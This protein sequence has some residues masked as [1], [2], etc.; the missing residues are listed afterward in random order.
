MMQSDVLQQT[1]ALSHI[2]TAP[3]TELPAADCSTPRTEMQAGSKKS[4]DD[5]IDE[6]RCSK[7][8]PQEEKTAPESEGVAAQ[9]VGYRES[10]KSGSDK[11]LLSAEKQN[12]G[13]NKP[14]FRRMQLKENERLSADIQ[15]PAVP[16]KSDSGA[17]SVLVRNGGK[18][19]AG[20][21]QN[22]A[23]RKAVSD[24]GAENESRGAENTSDAE[25][26]DVQSEIDI[27]AE[28]A[29]FSGLPVRP[30]EPEIL[31]LQTNS[32]A[33]EIMFDNPDT[34]DDISSAAKTPRRFSLDKDGKIIVS[35]FRSEK[36]P[37]VSETPAEKQTGLKISDVK[38]DRNTAEMTV[39]LT[40][41][42]T[43]QMNM[44]SSNNQTASA[45]GSQFQ[46]MLTN[47][48][49]QSAPEIVKAGSVILKDND[50]G[51]I[52][53]VLNPESLG[54]V[55]IDLHISEKAVTGRI[56]VAS[57]EAYNAFKE[58]ADSLRQ[59]FIHSGFESAGFDV[60]YSGQNSSAGQGG[61]HQNT[62]AQLNAVHAYG[63]L[64]A[65]SDSGLSSEE[66]YAFSER[67]SVNIVA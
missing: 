56:V 40:N 9:N 63:E 49:Q 47:Q 10:E 55:K 37:E 28:R 20:E 15:Q 3:K 6:A 11:K 34:I 12:G 1:A 4:F 51:Q 26:T 58:S 44:L 45:D 17:E 31:P 18:K 41:A 39:E 59:A 24:A 61:H 65:G 36:T 50:S 60:S 7:P 27:S 21:L 38:Y 42:E 23:V 5:M 64:T 29:L 62:E 22:S 46:A 8:V 14:D 52:K 57:Q 2:L 25:K 30:P 66:N 16:E 53:L 19:I 48:I 67:N 43:A 33:A 54:S 13:E 35:D 32:D